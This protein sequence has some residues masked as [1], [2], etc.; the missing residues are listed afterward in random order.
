MSSV[1]GGI[2]GLDWPARSKTLSGAGGSSPNPAEKFSEFPHP[3][4]ETRKPAPCTLRR[5][6]ERDCRNAY[7]DPI[8]RLRKRS[9]RKLLMLMRLIDAERDGTVTPM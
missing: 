3:K 4:P 5:R 6:A 8:K 1:N 7:G 9:M 2:C